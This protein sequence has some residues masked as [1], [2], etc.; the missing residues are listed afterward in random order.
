MDYLINYFLEP[1]Q[2]ILGWFSG[3]KYKQNRLPSKKGTVLM[4]KL[5]RFVEKESAPIRENL[6]VFLTVFFGKF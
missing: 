4:P 6:V 2:V 1:N 3:G 5:I